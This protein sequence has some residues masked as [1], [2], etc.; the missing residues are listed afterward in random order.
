MSADTTVTDGILLTDAAAIKVKTLL[1]AEGRDLT[2]DLSV[3]DTDE[4]VRLELSNGVLHHSGGAFGSGPAPTLSVTRELLDRI[5]AG[6]AGPDEVAS[7][8]GAGEGAEAFV[9]LIGLLDQ[10]SPWFPIVEP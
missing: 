2:L 3:T 4:R 7:E 9:N 6:I 1:E 10:F 8:L 5:A